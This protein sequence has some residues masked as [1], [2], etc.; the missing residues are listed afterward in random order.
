MRVWNEIDSCPRVIQFVAQLR[1]AESFILKHSHVRVTDVMPNFRSALARVLVQEGAEMRKVAEC[2]RDGV[3]L[4][5]EDDEFARA[6]HEAIVRVAAP[7]FRVVAVS[8]VAEGMERINGGLRPDVVLVDMMLAGPTSSP[9]HAAETQYGHL[10]GLD[11]VSRVRVVEQQRLRDSFF[12]KDDREDEGT[13]LIVSVSNVRFDESDVQRL[14]DRHGLDAVIRK[15][16]T[17]DA[18]RAVCGLS[19]HT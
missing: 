10:E 7:L 18:A 15:P 4:I 3:V 12:G 8:S 9:A 1:A 14:C 2:A 5:V 6:S 17:A 11:L 13:A 16:L 19:W